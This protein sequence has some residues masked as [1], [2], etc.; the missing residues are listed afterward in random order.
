MKTILC[1]GDSNTYGYNPYEGS[2]SRYPKEKRW[3]TLLSEMLGP[4]YDV[5][6]A[7]LNGRT[8]AYDRGALYWK[9][10]LKGLA[11][12]MGM[13]KPIDILIF[14]LGTNDCNTELNIPAA[15][16]AD[17]MERLI[18][19]A[20]KNAKIQQG[21]IPEMM[22]IV[23]GAIL[24]DFSNSPFEDKLSED[25]VRKSHEIAE[26]YEK[27][28]ERHDCKFLDAS[29]LIEVSELDSEHLTEKGHRQLAELIYEK[30]R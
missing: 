3:T 17:G 8:T 21:R 12:T 26:L 5:I 23:P 2:G 30:L 11:V 27:V 29:E 4:D 9:N 14:M 6:N 18:E 7:G 22:I 16:I 28:A 10:G 13:F 24:P 20:K 25:S 19:Q 1:Y 15:D